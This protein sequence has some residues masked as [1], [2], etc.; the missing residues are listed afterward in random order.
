[1]GSKQQPTVELVPRIA[2]DEQLVDRWLREDHVRR[3][4]G[5]PSTSARELESLPPGA[6]VRLIRADGRQAGLVVWQHPTRQELD[7]AGLEEIPTS[8]IDID[9]MVGE[10]ELTGRGIGTA[11]IRLAAEQAL[12]D[13][14]VPY[15][16]AAPKL[17]NAASRRAFEKAGFGVDREFDD[18]IFGPSVLMVLRPPR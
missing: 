4:W 14:T 18:P 11:A 7:E 8:V 6:Q 3:F 15:L 9:I 1:M 10:P 13:E 12:A 16:I 5:D 2:G 17:D